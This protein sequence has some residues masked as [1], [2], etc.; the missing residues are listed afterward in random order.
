MK[1]FSRQTLAKSDAAEIVWDSFSLQSSAGQEG[2]FGAGK[3]PG[4]RALGQ[5]AFL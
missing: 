2:G 4:L 1:L 3:G 5:Y